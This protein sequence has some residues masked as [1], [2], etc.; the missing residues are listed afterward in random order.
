MEGSDDD[1]VPYASNLINIASAFAQEDRPFSI[2][3]TKSTG[4]Y[5]DADIRLQYKFD[6]VEEEQAWSTLEK[7]LSA[8]ARQLASAWSEKQIELDK[9]CT[10]ATK[11]KQCARTPFALPRLRMPMQGKCVPT[12]SMLIGRNHSLNGKRALD[13]N[14]IMA[15]YEVLRISLGTCQ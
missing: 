15:S 14:V 7:T 11:S 13:L 10:A 2:W 4:Y 3:Y 5:K 1:S 8:R 6:V 12:T 9:A